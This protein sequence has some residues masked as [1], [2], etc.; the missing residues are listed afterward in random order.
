VATEIS[1]AELADRLKGRIVGD[2]DEGLRLTGTCAVG[3]YIKNK[4]TFV[5]N[6]KYGE[7]LAQLQDAVVLL[8]EN[9][10]DLC[11]KYPQNT[12]IMV[13]NV[14]ISL[15]DVQ[16]FFYSSAHI[17]TEASISPTAKIDESAEIGSQVYIGENVCIGGKV[18]I[19]EKTKIMHNSCLFDD[20]SVGSGTYIYPGVCIYKNCKIGNDCIIHSGVSIGVEG[21]RLEQD[22]EQKRVRKMIHVGGVVIGDRVEIGANAAIARAILEGEATV[23]SDDV[24]IDNLAHIAHNARIGARTIMAGIVAIAGSAKVG[25]DVW[26]GQGVSISNGVTVGNRAKL[27][28]NAVVAYDVGDDEVV[29]G[30]YAMPHRQWKKVW[31]KWKEQT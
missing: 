2:F 21:F 14:V 9:L 3:N 15:M 8:P 18:V 23:I 24:R 30:F 31:T 29:S 6:R 16:D 22:I 10:A 19:G 28:L 25:E 4:I 20:V 1:V 7:M 27:L 26:I 12:Y 5:R 11:E 13:G 17:I